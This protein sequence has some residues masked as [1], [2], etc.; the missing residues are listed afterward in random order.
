MSKKKIN[1]VW[2][3]GI[4]HKKIDFITRNTDIPLKVIFKAMCSYASNPYHNFGHALGVAETAIAIGQA[5]NLSRK[6]INIVALG[7]LHHDILHQGVVNINDELRSAIKTNLKLT[8]DELTQCGLTVVDRTRLRDLIIS[9]TFT[10]HG[11]IRD[12]LAEIIQDADISYMGKGPYMYLYACMGLVDEFGKQ[13]DKTIDPVVFIR[14]SQK[15]FIEHVISL[16]P[17]QDTFF[18]SPGAQKILQNPMDAIELLLSWKDNIFRLAYDLY[19]V[20]VDFDQFVKIIDNQRL[21]L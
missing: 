10:M 12:P 20:D 14:K 18:L 6:D 15:P 5:Q 8:D 17:N 7:G 4:N 19:K 13:I 16:S 1:H 21:L 3:S 2:K 11:K 9:T